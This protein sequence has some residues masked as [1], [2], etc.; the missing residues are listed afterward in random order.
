[1]TEHMHTDSELARLARLRRRAAGR[2]R[3]AAAEHKARV[4]AFAVH[5]MSEQARRFRLDMLKLKREGR[6]VFE[7]KESSAA[8]RGT[9]PGGS[10]R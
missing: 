4:A 5:M 8:H 1:M 6:R 3:V 7:S 10:R 2:E 9:E